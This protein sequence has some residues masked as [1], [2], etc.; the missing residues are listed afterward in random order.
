MAVNYI[1]SLK[2]TRMQAVVTACDAGGANASLEICSSAFAAVLVAIPLSKP[3]F[4]VA[5]DTITMAGAPKSAVAA[6]AGSAVVAR[7]KAGDG[8]TVVVNNLT[9]GTAGSDI[10]LINTAITA[11]QIVTVQ[12]GTIQH[13]P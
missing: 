12:S 2:T 13:A 1:M 10:N 5:T 11:G 9:V 4:T 3:S 8:A 7:I 6:A